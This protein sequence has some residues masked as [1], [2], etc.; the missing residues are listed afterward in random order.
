MVHGVMPMAASRMSVM[1]RLLVVSALMVFGGF[2]MMAGCV[3]V[4]LGRLLMVLGCFLGHVRFPLS[5]CPLG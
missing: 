5:D 2:G 4:M 1:G 3:G